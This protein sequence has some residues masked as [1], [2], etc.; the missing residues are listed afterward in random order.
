MPT[1]QHFHDWVLTKIGHGP[2]TAPLRSL[3]T[4]LEAESGRV[5]GG[6]TQL[7]EDLLVIKGMKVEEVGERGVEIDRCRRRIVELAGQLN[8][9]GEDR[10]RLVGMAMR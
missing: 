3:V 9:I 5:K 2:G 10:E 1:G 7:V 8:G 6:G 4:S